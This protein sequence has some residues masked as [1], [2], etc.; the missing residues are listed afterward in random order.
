MNSNFSKNRVYSTIAASITLVV[1]FAVCFVMAF[2]PHLGKIYNSVGKPS[3]SMTAKD[4]ESFANC[5]LLPSG[6]YT[7]DGFDPQMIFETS[8]H[9]ASCVKI[10]TESP[11]K[12]SVAFCVYTAT[13]P[14]KYSE[15]NC[16]SGCIFKDET[17]SVVEIPEGEYTQMRVDIEGDLTLQSFELYSAKP[18]LVQYSA[19]HTAVDYIFV[20]A[21][22]TLLA[23]AVWFVN[24]KTEFLKKS[25]FSLKKKR[26]KI[27]F[28]LLFTAGAVLLSLLVETV[29]AKGGSFNVYR[30]SFLFGAAELAVV[31]LFG[32]EDLK[33][34]PEKVFLG[35]VL[36][37]GFVML[38]GSP[39]MHIC[40]DLDSHYPMAV[41]ASYAVSAYSTAAD[42]LLLRT[43]T[44]T[45]DFNLGVYKEY[46][47]QL[48][49]ADG[50]IVSQQSATYSIAHLPAGL[51]IAVGR[52]FG[53]SFTA[54]YNLGRSAYLLVYS[55]V[56]YFAI[57]KIKSG[58]MILSVV[59]L[60]PTVIFMAT[61]YSYDYWVISF[62]M[63]GTAYYV[64]ILQEPQKQIT[65]VDTVIM[66]CA[67]ALA[68]LPKLVY[69]VMLLMPLFVIKEWDHKEKKRYYGIVVIVFAVV[70]VMFLINSLTQISGP[71]DLRG[72]AD[73]NPKGQILN[74]LSAPI[75]Y[76][77]LLT[78]FLLRYFSPKTSQ[79]Y[80]S[81]FAYMGVGKLYPAFILLMLFTAVTDASSDIKF[82]IPPFI[83][84]CSVVLFVGLSALIASALYI[85]FTPVGLETVKG[86]QPRYIIPLLPPLL[87]LVTGQR[88]N[89]FKNKTAYNGTVLG[90]SSVMVMI[91]T[92]KMIISRMI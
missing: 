42:K 79:E 56:C 25:L 24:Q 71:G 21:V 45:N 74:I 83:K 6:E 80:I 27:M 46:L 29:L 48:N 30:W 61:N 92:Y 22:P 68:S 72:G 70:F 76:A 78:K 86:C 64:S 10:N 59:A 23:A 38:F 65:V 36:V 16:Y 49:A 14:G 28:F 2:P 85:A 11:V 34:K 20:I 62:S 67:F 63:L 33:T 31:F 37:L 4:V 47:N 89:F 50:F 44:I 1:V 15:E 58:K 55:F 90:V 52:L 77:K 60:L 54:R 82:K 17:S 39:I 57:K 53:L 91:E 12:S 26:R 73:V 69:I 81:R 40:W 18:T 3:A 88:I 19:R 32:I 9:K 35:V 66:C 41:N 13:E 43:G 51:F 5:T 7:V 8:G 75:G 87:T 84:V